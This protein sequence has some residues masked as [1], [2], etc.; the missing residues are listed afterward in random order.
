MHTPTFKLE[1]ELHARG[2]HTIAGIDEVGCGALAGPVIAAAV[3]L[4]LDARLGLVRDSKLLSHN[5][6]TRLLPRLIEKLTGHAIGSSSVEEI[7]RFG[8]RRAAI[9]AM[10]RAFLKLS[11]ECALDFVL[12]D[13]WTIPDLSVPQ[14]A[15]VRG[16]RLVKSIAAASIVAKVYRDGLMEDLAREY[17]AYGFE[18]HRGYAT[19]VHE[20]RLRAHGPCPLHR[21]NFAPVRVLVASR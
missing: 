18:V 5:Q 19:R 11:E 6:R 9:L 2:Y 10:R 17:P 4:P 13:A 14:R 8:I 7:N 1:R 21:T 16:D 3:I 15:V 12:V 20:E